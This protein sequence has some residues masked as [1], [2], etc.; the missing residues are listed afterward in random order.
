MVRLLLRP[1]PTG[2]S[3]LKEGR[4][5]RQEEKPCRAQPI[6]ARKS[7]GRS[8]PSTAA[9]NTAANAEPFA[10]P[11]PIDEPLANRRWVEPAHSASED[12]THFGP[13]DSERFGPAWQ[14]AADTG[15]GTRPPHGG[16]AHRQRL[17]ATL[18]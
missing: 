10:P 16:G 14:R 9:A 5:V 3:S 13:F 4:N 8:P 6:G 1:F 2:I 11:V 17:A 18:D 15:A 12:P 7:R